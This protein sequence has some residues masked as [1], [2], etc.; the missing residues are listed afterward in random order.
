MM[1]FDTVVPTGGEHE[2]AVDAVEA[3]HAREVA[4]GEHRALVPGAVRDS[5]F[6]SESLLKIKDMNRNREF[7]LFLVHKPPLRYNRLYQKYGL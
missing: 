2:T 6:F 4:I 1:L 3:R 5:C 7:F